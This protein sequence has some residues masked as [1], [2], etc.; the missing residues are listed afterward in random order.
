MVLFDTICR[1][2]ADTPHGDPCWTHDSPM[3]ALEEFLQ[4]NPAFESDPAATGIDDT[5]STLAHRQ[6][7]RTYGRALVRQAQ[8]QVA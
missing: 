2:L 7:V 3:T 8:L 6:H 5:G 4:E 1:E